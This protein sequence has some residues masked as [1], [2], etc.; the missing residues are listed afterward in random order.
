MGASDDYAAM[1]FSLNPRFAALPHVIPKVS[2][3]LCTSILKFNGFCA[4]FVDVD[5]HM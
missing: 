4:A 5:I 1:W 3:K 2:R